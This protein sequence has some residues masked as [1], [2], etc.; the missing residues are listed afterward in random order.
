M[1][2]NPISESVIDFE[3]PIFKM[4]SNPLSKIRLDYL[5]T[6]GPKVLIC[7]RD[8]KTGSQF[9]PVSCTAPVRPDTVTIT[10]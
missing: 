4:L 9:Y 3:Q 10:G 7:E 5:W 6:T 2:S 1:W 8:F